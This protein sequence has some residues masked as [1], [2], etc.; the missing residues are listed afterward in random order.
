MD[1]YPQF[2]KEYLNMKETQKTTG[3]ANP[4]NQILGAQSQE[5]DQLIQ[6]QY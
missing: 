4:S 2:M 6:K 3:N 1:G 5:T